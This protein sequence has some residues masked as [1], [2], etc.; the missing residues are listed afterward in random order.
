MYK[1]LLARVWWLEAIFLTHL[2][3][4]YVIIEKWPRY[5]HFIPFCT[6]FLEHLHCL[7]NCLP[8]LLPNN[9]ILQFPNLL[10]QHL[11]YFQA[12]MHTNFRT[13]IVVNNFSSK[14]Q[15]IPNFIFGH[16]WTNFGWN[17]LCWYWNVLFITCVCVGTWSLSIRYWRHWFRVILGLLLEQAW[18]L[19]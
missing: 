2:H 11:I 14:F 3:T 17:W 7:W 15:I 6:F 5:I 18:V 1:G 8:L 19:G 13:V 10:L 16:S 12:Q 4:L 9:I